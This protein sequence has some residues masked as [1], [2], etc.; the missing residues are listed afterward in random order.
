MNHNAMKI[1]YK[2]NI[3][4]KYFDKRYQFQGFTALAAAK[5]AG[6]SLFMAKQNPNFWLKL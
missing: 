6:I 5:K 1:T 4:N 3:C 2:F